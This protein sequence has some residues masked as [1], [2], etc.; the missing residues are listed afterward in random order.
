MTLLRERKEQAWVFDRLPQKDELHITFQRENYIHYSG[1]FLVWDGEQILI[2]VFDMPPR[3]KKEGGG[4]YCGYWRGISIEVK[5]WMPLPNPPL[6][7][8]C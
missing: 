8:N 5:A 6:E 4:H 7:T 3:S 1:R 2:N